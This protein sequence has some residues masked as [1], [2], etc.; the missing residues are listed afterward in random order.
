M[1]KMTVF[2]FVTIFFFPGASSLANTIKNNFHFLMFF[3]FTFFSFFFFHTKIINIL[4]FTFHFYT[5]QQTI[6]IKWD[7]TTVKMEAEKNLCTENRWEKAQ[8]VTTRPSDTDMHPDNTKFCLHWTLKLFFFLAG[9]S[10]IEALNLAATT[11]K[12]QQITLDP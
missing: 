11:W 4:C 12:G 5:K 1:K 10:A 8:Y 2:F 3:C 7:K 6:H 9:I